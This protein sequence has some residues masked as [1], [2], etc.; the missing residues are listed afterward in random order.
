MNANSQLSPF[1]PNSVI[2]S[3]FD[4][5]TSLHHLRIHKFFCTKKFRF[6]MF[7]TSINECQMMC[8]LKSKRKTTL[9]CSV[10]IKNNFHILCI[11]N[12]KEKTKILKFS[13]KTSFHSVDQLSPSK[14]LKVK[15]IFFNAKLLVIVYPFNGKYA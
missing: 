10:Y 3:H 15:I 9:C 7:H 1:S 14:L 6:T 13:S 2:K 5:K 4:R 12:K 11:L 8:L